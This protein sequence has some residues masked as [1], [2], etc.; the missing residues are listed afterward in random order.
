MTAELLEQLINKNVFSDDTIIT[1]YYQTIDSFGR[2][3][4]RTTECKIKNIINKEN[5]YEFELIGLQENILIKATTDSILS[6]DGMTL[7]RYADIYDLNPD[8]TNKK[9]GRK[10]G[11]KPKL[12]IGILN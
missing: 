11:R 10:R 12:K 3:F 2:S 7:E 4:K 6:I 1:A 5:K 8:G 9:V